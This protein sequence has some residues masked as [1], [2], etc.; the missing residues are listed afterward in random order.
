MKPRL[1]SS[2]ALTCTLL[3]GFESARGDT[4]TLIE[5]TTFKGNGVAGG[6]VNGTI[7]KETPTEIVIGGAAVPLDQVER[8]A[9]DSPASLVRA[10]SLANGSDQ[11]RAAE[12]FAKAAEEAKSTPFPLQAA[13]FGQA[14]ALA[15]LAL[16]EPERADKV[17]ELLQSFL[18][19]Y[20]NS[21]HKAPALELSIKLRLLKGDNAG[22]REAAAELGTI[23]WAKGRAGILDAE[24]NIKDGKADAALAALDAAL[25]GA[26]KG[27]TLRRDALL[28]KAVALAALKRSDEASKVAQEVIDAAN[29]DDASTQA[30]AYNTLGDCYAEA[31]K[32]KDALLAYLHTE[33]LY[34]A[35]KEQHA[36]ALAKISQTWRVLKRDDRANEALARLQ[37]QYPKS[38]WL[39]AARAAN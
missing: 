13:K 21:R 36:R 30:L 7:E 27:S 22:A 32:P 35:D 37:E 17:I 24:V 20:P 3:A 5:G 6:R 4:V 19:A 18:K 14:K 10:A 1:M 39:A 2:L 16:A 11:A 9:Y 8:V 23:P 31:N 25:G 15:S 12:E 26:P 38:P 34:S 28:A 33:I 29:P